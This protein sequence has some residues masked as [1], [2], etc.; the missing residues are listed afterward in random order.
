MLSR[1]PVYTWEMDEKDRKSY[2]PL[3]MVRRK[4]FEAPQW[5][6]LPAW[7]QFRYS[8]PPDWT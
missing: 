8:Q 6:K 7:L 1:P 4:V 2:N 5:T 3:N